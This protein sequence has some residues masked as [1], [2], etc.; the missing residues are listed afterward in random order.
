MIPQNRCGNGRVSKRL[1]IALN[2]IVIRGKNITDAAKSTGYT[3][4]ALHHAL[5]K[6]HVIAE[7]EAIANAFLSSAKD[8]AMFTLVDLMKN[9]K[10]DDVKHKSARTILELAGSIGKNGT[11]S[12]EIGGDVV[13]NI[14]PM[15]KHLINNQETNQS[16]DAD[17]KEVSGDTFDSDVG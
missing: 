12:L 17:F 4:Q 1:R 10:S 5:N 14:V 16:I 2:E 11:N 8:L 15:H 9:A 7:K 6:P 3:V 13:I